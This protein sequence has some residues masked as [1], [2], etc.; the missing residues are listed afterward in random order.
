MLPNWEVMVVRLIGRA[1]LRRLKGT[2]EQTEKWVRSWASEVMNAH[3]KQP[4]DVVKQ[5][6]KAKHDGE[7]LFFFPVGECNWTIHL[8]ITFSQGV[9][10]VTNINA[11][12]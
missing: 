10:L 7:G 4:S 6:P 1:K 2:G 5:F 12:N 11:E 9:A 3:W 8:L